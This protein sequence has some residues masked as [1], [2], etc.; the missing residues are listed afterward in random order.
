MLDALLVVLDLGLVELDR[1]LKVYVPLFPQLRPSSPVDLL[2]HVPHLLLDLGVPR[3]LGM[4]GTVLV[5]PC[6]RLGRFLHVRQRRLS[7]LLR[8]ALN[9]SSQS[10]R[11]SMLTES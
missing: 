8:L 10:I 2:Q 7:P 11:L 4:G 6:L 9:L 3:L 5:R 1:L